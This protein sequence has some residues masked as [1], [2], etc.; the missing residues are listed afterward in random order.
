MAEKARVTMLLMQLWYLCAPWKQAPLRHDPA[1][2]AEDYP[3][4][5]FSEPEI[6]IVKALAAH[7][8]LLGDSWDCEHLGRTEPWADAIRI[9]HPRTHDEVLIKKFVRGPGQR[10]ASFLIGAGT[11]CAEVDSFDVLVKRLSF[12]LKEAG[13][14]EFVRDLVHK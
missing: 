13:R 8:K 1:L 12:A 10:R 6:G 9:S 14:D 2:T 4:A 3:H 7:A 5:A 11:A